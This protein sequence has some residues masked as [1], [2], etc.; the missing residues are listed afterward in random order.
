MCVFHGQWKAAHGMVSC[1][2]G[3][4]VERC[5]SALVDWTMAVEREV[6]LRWWS[7]LDAHKERAVRD[8][9]AE[10]ACVVWWR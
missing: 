7:V 3:R 2:S 1:L 4:A 8:E 5:G 9:G 10:A 6:L